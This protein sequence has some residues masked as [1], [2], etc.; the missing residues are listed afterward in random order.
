MTD[1]KLN[2]EF[3]LCSCNVKE[4]SIGPFIFCFFFYF[5]NSSFYMINLCESSCGYLRLSFVMS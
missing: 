2:M 3:K 1:I 5:K 4:F